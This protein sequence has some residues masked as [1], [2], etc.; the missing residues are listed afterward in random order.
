[1]TGGNASSRKAAYREATQTAGFFC[2]PDTTLIELRG[3]DCKSFL[4]NLCTADI[5]SL[6]AGEGCELFFT[7]V[8]GK[9][10]GYG[11]AF[12]D[13]SAIV[14]S[15]AS[16]QA[17]TL[18][19]HLDRYLIREDVQ[20]IDRSV[21]WQQWVLCGPQAEFFC[22]DHLNIWLDPKNLSH[23]HTSIEDFDIRVCRTDFLGLPG[24]AI[25]FEATRGD[26][27]VTLLTAIAKECDK[28]IFDFLR[29]EAG[30]PLFGADITEQNLPQ[31]IDR[32]ERAISFTKGC[33]L[34]QETV[35][36]IDALGQVQQ[37][38][39]KLHFPAAKQTPSPGIPLQ[40]GG[41]NVGQLT[42]ASQSPEDGRVLAL[43]MIRRAQATAGTRLQS[44]DGDL[45][46]L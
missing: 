22:Q 2:C 27:L 13:A 38:L 21:E 18:L 19:P 1:M 39:R 42:S 25:Q 7:N 36:R 15:T 24:F 26:R 9:T 11:W 12:I 40:S 28:T 45:E 46:V 17:S 33:Y 16:G 20:L 43:G 37:L 44:S 41:Q 32:D 5:N 35:A 23:V 31:E 34:G 29:I 30:S 3:K 10:L 8:Q 6:Q 4:H 14:V